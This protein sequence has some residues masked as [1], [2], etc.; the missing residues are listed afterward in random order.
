MFKLYLNLLSLSSVNAT[1]DD[2]TFLK[3]CHAVNLSPR[4]QQ[5]LELLPFI[6][7]IAQLALV[8]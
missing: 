3:N 5:V 4:E 7:V 2:E 6:W 8:L 1:C